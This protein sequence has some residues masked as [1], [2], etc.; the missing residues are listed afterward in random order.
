MSKRVRL[1]GLSFGLV[2]PWLTFEAAASE[3]QP[4]SAARGAPFQ[5]AGAHLDEA[6]LLYTRRRQSD[7]TFSLSFRLLTVACL[8]VIL[9]S[10]I[11]G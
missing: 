5:S 9:Q 8:L 10:S 7:S 2:L 6:Q 4:N 1:L 3:D 11:D